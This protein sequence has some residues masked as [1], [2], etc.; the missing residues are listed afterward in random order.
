M[1]ETLELRVVD[2]N[3]AGI[4]DKDEGA[5]FAGVG[6]RKVVLSSADSRL[7]A[8]Q[9]RQAEL[10][11]EGRSLYLGWSYQRRYSK[12]ELRDAALLTLAGGWSSAL[13]GSN[14]GTVY[15]NAN[16]CPVCGAGRTRLSPLRLH[17]GKIPRVKD[18]VRAG[19][20][21]WIVSEHFVSAYDAAKATGA[22]FSPVEFPRTPTERAP[23]WFVLGSEAPPVSMQG[24]TQF[25]TDALPDAELDGQY[26]CPLGDTVGFRRI[27]EIRISEPNAPL[28]DTVET[29]EYLGSSQGWAAPYRETLISGRL[30]QALLG[31]G[32]RGLSVEIARPVTGVGVV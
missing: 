31:A 22:S 26:V 24:G 3:D 11:R 12:A 6:I 9:A 4:F 30:Y 15:E 19:S 2:A 16:A 27:S 21:E 10:R 14:A 20:G 32:V 7:A 8:I 18:I 1:K 17:L 25:A 13:A 5:L 23:R 28:M 29:R